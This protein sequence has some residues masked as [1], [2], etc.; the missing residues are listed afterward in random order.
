MGHERDG[1][2]AII[3][4][5]DE[6]ETIYTVVAGTMRHVGGVLVVDNGSRDMTPLL[7]ERAGA[8][9][10]REPRRGYGAACQRGIRVLAPVNPHVVVFMSGDG[11]DDPH[12]IPKVLAP[13]LFHGF[14]MALGRRSCQAHQPLAQRMGNRF[15]T[16]ASRR[17]LG[18]GFSDLGPLRAILWKELMALELRDRGF[19]WTLEMQLK[20]CK[21]GLNIKEVPVKNR[22]RQGGRQKISGTFLGTWRAGRDLMSCLGREILGA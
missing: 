2:W 1:I 11:S 20:A 17:F 22:P 15:I 14:H 8:R 9:V 10:V 18:A 4:A 12:D 19:A 16:W 13:I 3:P 5:L 6:E 21:K 7:A